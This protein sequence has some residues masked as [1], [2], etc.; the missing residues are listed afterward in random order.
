MTPLFKEDME[1]DVDYKDDILD[2]SEPEVLT[3][4][5]EYESICLGQTPNVMTS[6]GIDMLVQTLVEIDHKPSTTQPLKQISTPLTA[7]PSVCYVEHHSWGTGF[8]ESETEDSFV[9]YFSV[10]DIRK[11][12]PKNSTAIR[13]SDKI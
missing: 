8:I 3:E 1:E 4:P 5:N 12:I 7:T 13:H 9:V 2:S 6:Q 10:F 11:K